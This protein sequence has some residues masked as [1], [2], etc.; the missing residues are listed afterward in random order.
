MRY[1]FT[2][3]VLLLSSP[4]FAQTIVWDKVYGGSDYDR[5]WSMISNSDGNIVMVGETP[6]SDYDVSVNFGDA[7]CW[8]VCIDSASGEVLWQNSFGGSNA[9]MGYNIFQTSDKG[10]VITGQTRSRDSGISIVGPGAGGWWWDDAWVIKTDSIGNLQW[11]RTIG[12]SGADY[13]QCGFPNADG[14][15]IVCGGTQWDDTVLAGFHGS[16]FYDG[17]VV[18]LDT[19]G[20]ILWSRCL[21]GT[22]QDI[23]YACTAGPEGSIVVTGYSFSTDDDL[24]GADDYG[25]LWVMQVDSSGNKLWSYRYGSFL[26]AERGNDITKTKDGGYLVAGTTEGND[27]DVSGNHGARDIWLLKLDSA[28]ILQWQKCYGGS[29][30]EDLSKVQALSNG[31]FL[32]FGSTKSNDGDVTGF[33]SGGPDM[34]D[35]WVF[36]I[37]SVGN[38]LWDKAYGGNANDWGAGGVAFDNHTLFLGGFATSAD[39]DKTTYIGDYDFWLLK[40]QDTTTTPTA[41]PHATV[42][43]GISIYPTVSRDGVF[44]LKNPKEL[45]VRYAVYDMSGKRIATREETIGTLS[46]IKLQTAIPGIYQVAVY[47]RENIIMQEKIIVE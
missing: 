40:V 8:V 3:L 29:K 33:H 13:F 23:I 37:D 32:V 45:P 46:R 19:A 47:S 25:L 14:S 16:D 39:G 15:I 18:K 10:Y 4:L 17:L 6:S 35:Y 2:L 34:L 12:G 30:S 11:Q 7:D 38:L 26:F 44:Y 42:S 27:G 31:N 5:L 22:D 24:S 43:T 20:N 1:L 9:D 28:G 21:G 36:C 41:V